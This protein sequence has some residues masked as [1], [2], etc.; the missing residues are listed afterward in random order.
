MARGW[1]KSSPKLTKNQPPSPT[2]L[3]S[4]VSLFFPLLSRTFSHQHSHHHLSHYNLL[5]NQTPNH[6][7]WWLHH[8]SLSLSLSPL[9]KTLLPLCHH[10][11]S[12]I[13][14]SISR[15]Y[16]VQKLSSFPTAAGA[17]TF[18]STTPTVSFPSPLKAYAFS[19]SSCNQ[20][21]PLTSPPPVTSCVTSQAANSFHTR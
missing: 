4:I 13:R 7:T 14:I 21:Q 11:P 19:F 16:L 6:L 1:R 2:F 10:D 20:H 9:C 5:H 17:T 8:L 15:N 3:F 12:S 18:S